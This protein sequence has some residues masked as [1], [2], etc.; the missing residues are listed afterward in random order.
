[1]KIH[2]F[3]ILLAFLFTMSA[4]RKKEVFPDLGKQIQGRWNIYEALI[5]TGIDS[6]GLYNPRDSAQVGLIEVRKIDALRV[7]IK[8]SIKKDN[9]AIVFE[10]GYECE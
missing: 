4:C 5:Y 2:R 3:L 1:M 7:Q 6:T 9:G 10:S 8:M